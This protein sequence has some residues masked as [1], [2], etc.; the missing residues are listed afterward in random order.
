MPG[1]IPDVQ[2]IKTACTARVGIKTADGDRSLWLPVYKTL[3]EMGEPGKASGA[4]RASCVSDAAVLF[5]VV[6]SIYHGA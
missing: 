5:G 6:R 4:I 1:F 3:H 2:G